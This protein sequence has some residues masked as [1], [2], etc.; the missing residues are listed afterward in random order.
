MKVPKKKIR[1][2]VGQTYTFKCKFNKGAYA[3]VFI[4]FNELP[5]FCRYSW[6]GDCI[7]LRAERPI[8]RQITAYTINGLHDTFELEIYALTKK[9]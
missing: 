7:R 2:K 6:G 9:K 4:D 8:K 5:Q 1:I 3:R